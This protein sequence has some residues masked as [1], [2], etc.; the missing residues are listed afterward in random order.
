MTKWRLMLPAGLL[1][2]GGAGCSDLGTEPESP[3][4]A[5]APVSFAADLQP[6]FAAR[7]VVCHGVGGNAGLDLNA[8]VAWDNLV[9]VVAT[10]YG[11]RERVVAGNPDQSVLFLKVSGDVTVGDR[12]PLGGT[13]DTETIEKI[14]VWIA[15]GALQN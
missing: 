3:P 12:M 9:G 15:Q 14:R 4:S 10:N 11:P 7:C 5:A 2:L 6:V 13:L 1:L 8:A